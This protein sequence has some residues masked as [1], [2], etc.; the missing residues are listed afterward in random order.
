MIESNIVEGR[1]DIPKEG[2]AGLEY[3]KSI[4]DACVS[5][6]DTVEMLRGLAEAVK[7]RRKL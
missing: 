1:Q 6:E 5:W 7:E 3:G 2:P 4:T